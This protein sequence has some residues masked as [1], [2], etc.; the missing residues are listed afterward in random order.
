[1]KHCAPSQPPLGAVGDPEPQKKPS[2]VHE[3]YLY[4]RRDTQQ[5]I[6]M[7][8]KVVAP[9]QPIPANN[10]QDGARQNRTGPS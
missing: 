10:R 1:M 8:C 4:M 5:S 6:E 2:P 9:S 7:S 3:R